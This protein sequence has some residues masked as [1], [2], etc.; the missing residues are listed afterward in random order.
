[1]IRRWLQHK[2]DPKQNLENYNKLNSY[3]RTTTI[4]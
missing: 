3:I 2:I 4:K 1:M